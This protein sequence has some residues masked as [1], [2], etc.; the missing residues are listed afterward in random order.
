MHVRVAIKYVSVHHSDGFMIGKGVKETVL[1][2]VV[3]LSLPA[4]PRMQLWSWQFMAILLTVKVNFY[5]F[6]QRLSVF[7]S[8]L[9]P[10]LCCKI[11]ACS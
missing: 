2:F 11:H 1:L 5:T 6:V 10:L 7:T 9:I 8:V 4:S 3:V